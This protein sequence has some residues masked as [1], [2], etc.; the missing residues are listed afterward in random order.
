MPLLERKT[1]V[2]LIRAVVGHR[3]PV[4]S[5]ARVAP[6]GLCDTEEAGESQSAILRESTLDPA[7]SQGQIKQ[8]RETNSA[9]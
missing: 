2:E 3:H 1:S 8:N 9:F 4:L 7:S 6:R 5:G